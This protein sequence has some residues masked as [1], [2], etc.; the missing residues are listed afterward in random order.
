[1]RK[2]P[3]VVLAVLG[4]AFACGGAQQGEP[5][6]NAAPA[7]PPGTAAATAVAPS[8]SLTPAPAEPP[9]ATAASPSS[10]AE[11]S[12]AA[13]SAASA[14]SPEGPTPA[15]SVVEVGEVQ[16]TGGAL[17]NLNDA[18]ATLRTGLTSCV[19]RARA[20]HPDAEGQVTVTIRV[21]LAGQVLGVAA[22]QTT[23]IPASL[24]SCISTRAATAQFEPPHSA[25]SQ[26][27]VVIPVTVPKP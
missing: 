2:S 14:A 25:K 18:V 21:G 12:P 24:V 5:A 3:L 8:E 26:V 16:T 9:S 10:S 19:A 27:S 17:P 23:K 7:A 11:V 22:Q 6:V 20:Q 15:P 4:T 13:S 1:M